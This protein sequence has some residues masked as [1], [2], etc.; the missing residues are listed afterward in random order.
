[1]NP[2]P[3]PANNTEELQAVVTFLGLLDLKYVKP[4]ANWLDKIPNTDGQIEIVDENQRPL[5]KLEVQIKKIPDGEM[6]FQC[7]LELI[8]YSQKISIPFLLVCVDVGNKKAYFRHL[9]NSIVPELKPDQQSFSIKFDPKVHLV[10]GETQYLRQWIEIVQE[11]N[12]RVSDYPR[13]QQIV[14][15][16]NL[17]HISKQDNIYFQEFIDHLNRLLEFDFPIVK[18]QFFKDV[19]KL[20]V[21]VSSADQND[22]IFQIYKIYPGDP[23]IL[24]SGMPNPF[25]DNTSVAGQ[26]KRVYQYNS[27]ARSVLKS[28]KQEAGSFV[29]DR[30]KEIIREKKLSICGKRLATEY[31]FWFVD[32]Y[33]ASVGIEEADR[34]NVDQLNY[35]ISVYLPAWASIA[36]PRFLGELIRLNKHNLQAIVPAIAAPPFESIRA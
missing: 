22:V 1:M 27:R 5:G 12:K 24:V 17:S 4:E 3:Y 21:G 11:Y 36:V 30:L 19:W 34:L 25:A 15:D 2:A 23:A 8:A 20:G 13:L 32:H 35:G 9:Q 26:N 7:P 29:F 10:S 6:S 16:L 33:G 14:S 18:E 28:A 31:L